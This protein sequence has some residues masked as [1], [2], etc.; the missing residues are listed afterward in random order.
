MDMNIDDA[1]SRAS[2]SSAS[3]A[4]SAGSAG[5]GRPITAPV[6]GGF[7]SHP[8]RAIRTAPTPTNASDQNVRVVARVRP[9]SAKELDENSAES[10]LAHP[11]LNGISVAS[12]D[13][14]LGGTSER[15]KFE[16]DSVFAPSATQ[17][18]VYQSTCGDMINGSIFK[19]FNATILAYGQT[20]SGKT[21]TMG[22][23]GSTVGPAS[24][25]VIARA[26]YDLFRAQQALPNGDERVKVT[27]S[28]LEIYNEQAV[29]LLNDDTSAVNATLQVRDSKTEGVVIPNLKHFAV[30]S[31]EEVRALIEKASAKRATGSTHMNSVSS[32]SHAICTLT[33]TIAPNLDGP[34]EDSESPRSS[35]QGMKAKL[36]LVDLAGSERLKRTGAEGS[37][38]KEGI[39]INKGL[40]VLGQVV[41]A[42]SEVGQRGGGSSNH[43]HIPY[44]DSKLTRL[45]QDS[46][47]GNSRTVMIACISPAESNIEESINTL[48]YAERTRNIKNSAVRNVV[49]AGLS[50]SEAAALRRENQ[51]L[52]LE[53]ARMESK[54][55]VSNAGGGSGA[56]RFSVAGG[57]LSTDNMEATSRLQAQ[58]SSLL[59]E[60][61]LL[62]GRAG[63][64]AKEVLEA[65]L[66][67]DKWQAKSEAI[68]QLAKSQGVDLADDNIAANEDV[69]SQLRNQLAESKAELLEARTEAAVARA[70]A[71]AILASNGD[72]S[73]IEETLAKDGDVLAGVMSEE[74]AARNEL[75]T[76]EL[77]GVSATIEQKEAMLLQMN[78]ER[79]VH[80]NLQIHYEN[81]LRLMQAEVDTLTAERDDLVVKVSGSEKEN[82]EGNAQR[83]NKR[84]AND[85]M[86]K[87]L[88]DQISKLEDRIEELR[89]KA[90]EH[91]RSMKMKEQAEKKCERL[92]AEIVED[93][94]RRADL[95]RKLKEASV[96][97]RAEKRM[98]KQKAAKMLK[99]SQRLK[100]ELAKTK[101]V[102]QKQA[103][104]LKRK[105]DQAAAKEKVRAEME[106]KRRS[107]G[108]MRL[109]STSM[110]GGD[111]KEGRKVELASWVDREFEY[112][113]IKVQIDEQRRQLDEAVSD[114]RKLVKSGG[115]AVDADELK[116]VDASIQSLRATVHDLEMAAKRAFPTSA[117]GGV[118]STFRFL[119]T[120][121]FKGLSKPDAKYV[122]S[123]IFD[124]CSSVKKELA[125]LVASQE[126]KSK[127]TVDSALA[128]EQQLHQKALIQLKMEHAALTVSL[129]QS[130]QDTVNS[131]I[132]LKVDE[133]GGD[134]QLKA[135]VD[136]IVG[137][138]NEAWSAA[139]GAIESDLDDINEAQEEQQAMMD[140]IANGMAVAP[141]K[142]KAK[143]K[144]VEHDYDSEAFESE[145]SFMDDGGEDSEYEPTPAKAK[146][147]RRSPR[148]AKKKAAVPDSPASP[149]GSNFIDDIEN[150][151]VG[152]LKKACKKLGVPLTG[153][154]ADLQQRVKE[155]L[156]NSSALP[157]APEENDV[158]YVASAK[159]V[160][161]LEG[162]A[163]VGS[164]P[165]FQP[166]A[167]S[168]EP[169]SIKKKLWDESNDAKMPPRTPKSALKTPNR[170][171][172]IDAKENALDS[173]TPSKRHRPLGFLSSS[174][175]PLGAHDDANKTPVHYKQTI[176]TSKKRLV[177]DGKQ[178]TAVTK[179]GGAKKETTAS[180]KKRKA[181]R[182][183]TDAVT[184][185]L[186][187]NA[188][189][190][191]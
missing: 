191:S 144:R 155:T 170:K 8:P 46:L 10:I 182:G 70:T 71:G 82:G 9:L 114:R 62:K 14:S 160:N 86:T 108:K 128:K 20:G 63:G 159:K 27:M 50:A 18:E 93:K 121:T 41:S 52:K 186:Q 35:S 188:D 38:M 68:V 83:R 174:P 101:S 73:N 74:D 85:P 185:A 158:P 113:A 44:R 80:D 24:E 179:R 119:E 173:A 167:E 162:H 123:Y 48:R 161:F 87:K 39:N 56:G 79:A 58:C 142:A 184:K 11:T 7:A 16:F 150:K 134:E 107:A 168:S 95:Q 2:T 72:L 126:A 118:S 117:D 151:K 92:M 88:R 181:R 43:A 102:A 66:R 172:P 120:D 32:R 124:T 77:S 100:V 136:G 166:I 33:V 122:L 91:K 3:S 105:M 164:D 132:K 178:S 189:L 13:D 17:Q 29:D 49:S 30:G 1:P 143:K 84:K 125:A 64:H 146:R 176:A 23:D 131:N 156:L 183:M 15:R 53:L 67:A 111:I 106:R 65:S 175:R 115:D 129:L 145:E 127:T 12:P 69:V 97:M 45:L 154:K 26:V 40:F 110:D 75:L 165:E 21:F 187:Q 135:R 94:R 55:I 57:A 37:R 51:Q 99:D 149:I 180:G 130:T 157:S 148:I 177:P 90:N 47:G 138:Y 153:K 109:A 140:K 6:N 169:E 54:M 141:K 152:S 147:K 133:E 5:R 96:E 104:V 4:S 36:T 81:S 163:A 89:G 139:T 61:E 76:T 190:M 19:G 59:A 78:K 31:P 22:T 103:A 116:Q 42:L 34:G 112:S 25:G 28:Y 137:P 98:A 60:N 171:R